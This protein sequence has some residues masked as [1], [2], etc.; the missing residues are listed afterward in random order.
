MVAKAVDT[1]LTYGR[2]LTRIQASNDVTY[3]ERS[4]IASKVFPP[5]I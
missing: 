1:P 2:C 3:P 5:M 4:S